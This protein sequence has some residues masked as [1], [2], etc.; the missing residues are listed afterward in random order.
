MLYWRLIL[1]AVAISLVL[2][3][4]W[5]DQFGPRPGIFMLPLALVCAWMCAGEIMGL[6]EK[7]AA[8]RL[9]LTVREVR[10]E[11]T[12]SLPWR[13]LVYTATILTVLFATAP[14]TLYYPDGGVSGRTGWIAW[15]LIAGL[16]LSLVYEMCTYDGPDQPPGTITTR[17]AR[18]L[19]AITY[20]GGLTGF[21]VQL[22][23]I[24]GGVW[25]SAEHC[26]WG[27]LALLTTIA[28]VKMND[29]GAYFA[30]HAFGR[31]KMVP[32]LSPGKTWEGIIGGFI[33]S[34]V[35]AMFFLGP[36]AHW[37]GCEYEQPIPQWITSVVVYALIVG[38][39]GVLGDL[40]ISLLKRDANVKDSS[41]WMP[42]FGG[43]LDLLDSILLAAPVS[44]A[45]WM[46]HVVGP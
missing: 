23:I 16:L 41:T 17:I 13:P 39:A 34:I 37:L 19:L 26:S 10:L 30:G 43:F 4:A 28:T 33:G 42:G 12:E 32:K 5:L 46:G 6:Y 18:S 40:A 27:M 7:A 38:T 36:V 22:R 15:G 9:N 25:E 35:G 21:L 8:K 45:L 24:S 3:L 14:M 29:S 1:A 44:Y 2:G 31:H 11:R 20:A